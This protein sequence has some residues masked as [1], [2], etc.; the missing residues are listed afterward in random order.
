ML[1]LIAKQ[2][3]E[4]LEEIHN[5]IAGFTEEKSAL[6]ELLP[7]ESERDRLRTV[8]VPA[9]E[10]QLANEEEQLETSSKAAENVSLPLHWIAPD[11]HA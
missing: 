4:F 10:K 6:E 11:I 9:L 7:D 8:E 1:K 2:S 5:E 3:D